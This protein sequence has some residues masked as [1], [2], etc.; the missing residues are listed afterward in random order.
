MFD[1]I[2]QLKL[3]IETKL[4]DYIS[5][6]TVDN[7]TVLLQFIDIDVN[8]KTFNIVLQYAGEE[9]TDIGDSSNGY[10]S[11]V[12]ID[13]IFLIRK[14]KDP[15]LVIA[16]VRQGF[17]DFIKANNTLGDTVSYITLVKAVMDEEIEAVDSK[18]S[19]ALVFTIS[20]TRDV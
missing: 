18:G 16:D 2:E 7:K 20:T 13:V 14:T 4:N 9:F 15:Y 10:E 5:T 11:E 3:E 12:K 6:V 8:T 17:I 1:I 19:K